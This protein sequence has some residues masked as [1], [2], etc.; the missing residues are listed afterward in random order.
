MN[1]EADLLLWL[2]SVAKLYQ[3][4]LVH[5]RPA[6]TAKG[7]RT[8]VQGDGVGFPDIL[9][10]RGSQGIALELKSDTGRVRAEQLAWLDAFRATG[11][12][13]TVV[14]PSNRDEV[15]ALLSGGRA[16]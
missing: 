16:A 3:W 1:T 6:L 13:A 2:A 10:L 5:W 14:R 4:R 9:L 15:L 11:W 8:P 12:T 7:W